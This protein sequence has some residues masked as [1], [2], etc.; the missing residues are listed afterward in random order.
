MKKQ[1]PGF[2][3]QILEKY[4]K[5]RKEE[6]ERLRTN[7]LKK[8]EE[9]LEKVATQIKFDEAY[10]FGSLTKP[11]RFKKDSDIDIGF[12]GLKDEDFF[13]MIS[14]LSLEL[15]REV[16]VIQL[17]GHRLENKVKTEGIRWKKGNS[18]S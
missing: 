1:S 2:Q 11:G 13:K 4:L 9:A 10:I 14:Y 17:E 6:L 7:T 3:F 8:V 12:Y 15:E 18:Q 16:D 5:T